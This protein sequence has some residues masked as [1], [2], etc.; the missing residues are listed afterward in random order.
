MSLDDGLE[1]FE[2]GQ[3]SKAY[4]L[5]LPHARRGHPFAQQIVGSMM[6]LGQHM[7]T[8]ALLFSNWLRTATVEERERFWA[9]ITP[10]RQQGVEFLELA[11]AHG[12]W[13]ATN[14]LLV[15]RDSM[16]DLTYSVSV[17]ELAERLRTQV[18]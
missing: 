8:N 13:S 18:W 1:M 15:I 3:D 14:N 16:P 5:L 10:D 6:I 2:S 17:S 12:V 4:Q 11:S 7:F 9:S